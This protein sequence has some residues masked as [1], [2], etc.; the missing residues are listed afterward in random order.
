M[1][2]NNNEDAS[3]S[4]GSFKSDH[5]LSISDDESLFDDDHVRPP[6]TRIIIE[7]DQ[8]SLCKRCAITMTLQLLVLVFVAL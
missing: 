8:L 5:L 7:V 3:S 4:D 6:P 1:N 2:I